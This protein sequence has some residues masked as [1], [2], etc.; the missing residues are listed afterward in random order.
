MRRKERG[1]GIPD[2]IDDRI[3][4]WHRS[5][6]KQPLHEFLGV[7]EE[8]YAAWVVNGSTPSKKDSQR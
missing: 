8:E 4:E 3:D 6:S 5:N 7:A 1:N 2:D